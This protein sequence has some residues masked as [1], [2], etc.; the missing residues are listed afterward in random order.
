MSE[1]KLEGPGCSSQGREGCPHSFTDCQVKVIHQDR[2]V[3]E[4]EEGE[5]QERLPNLPELCQSLLRRLQPEPRACPEP[6]E[7]LQP[8]QDKQHRRGWLLLHQI[9]ERTQ[10]PLCPTAGS[11]GH[12]WDVPAPGDSR[13]GSCSS[14]PSPK[15]PNHDISGE[16]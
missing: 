16:L 2:M 11:P 4:W 9:Q 8:A 12:L 13:C 10:T 15:A 5:I 1:W 3:G 7:S 14:T 6:C